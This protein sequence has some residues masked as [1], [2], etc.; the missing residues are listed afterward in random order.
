M[1]LFATFRTSP[2]RQLL[3]LTSVGA[4]IT[5]HGSSPSGNRSNSASILRKFERMPDKAIPRRVLRQARGI[6]VLDIITGGS[7]SAAGAGLPASEYIRL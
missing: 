7:S 2:A 4:A 3:P 1:L 6:A 5:G